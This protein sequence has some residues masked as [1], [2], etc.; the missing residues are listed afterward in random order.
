MIVMLQ[1]SKPQ[2]DTKAFK[3]LSLL[4]CGIGKISER[5]YPHADYP[6]CA[7]SLLQTDV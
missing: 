2:K 4:I 5:K 6:D 7:D 3:H 1:A